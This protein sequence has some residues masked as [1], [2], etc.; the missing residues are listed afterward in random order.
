[1]RI[2]GYFTKPKGV[3]EQKS[4]KNTALDEGEWS[5]RSDRFIPPGKEPSTHW[6]VGWV[7]PRAGLDIVEQRN[8]FPLPRMKPG[9]A[10]RP[11]RRLYSHYTD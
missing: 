11:A 4:L 1:V 6:I 8:I 9:L 3:R 5:S 2:R 10:D 7:G